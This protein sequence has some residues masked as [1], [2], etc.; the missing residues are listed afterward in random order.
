MSEKA[1][2]HQAGNLS[3]FL[4]C[5]EVKLRAPRPDEYFQWQQ[6]DRQIVH[7]CAEQRRGFARDKEC[8]HFS[9]SQSSGE[10]VRQSRPMTVVLRDSR[11]EVLPLLIH[12]FSLGRGTGV[13]HRVAPYQSGRLSAAG[14]QSITLADRAAHFTL[15]PSAVRWHSTPPSE[16]AQFIPSAE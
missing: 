15:K 11:H 14:T 8:C 4:A 9:C 13:A 12:R 10:R 5:V 1:V 16:A 6:L 3:K 7:P 2:H